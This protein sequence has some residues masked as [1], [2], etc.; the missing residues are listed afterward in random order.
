M[1]MAKIDMLG[2]SDNSLKRS[3]GHPMN[4]WM[5]KTDIFGAHLLLKSR[6]LHMA[7]WDS[8]QSLFLPRFVPTLACEY[9]YTRKS[10]AQ[11]E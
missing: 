8:E 9:R 6:L 3:W 11:A 10:A 7:S 2:S 5:L 4:R 1:S